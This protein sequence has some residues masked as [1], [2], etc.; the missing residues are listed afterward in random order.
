[1]GSVA[2]RCLVDAVVHV[3]AGI[4]RVEGAQPSAAN[5]HALQVISRQLRGAFERVR[6]RG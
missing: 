3:R 6:A 5:V 2:S 1:M 4:V